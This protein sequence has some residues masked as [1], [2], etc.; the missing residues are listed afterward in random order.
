LK[1]RFWLILGGLA[2]LAIIVV[3]A[4][5]SSGSR[6]NQNPADLITCTVNTDIGIDKVTITNQNTGKSITKTMTDLPYTFNLTEG[7][8]LRLNVTLTEGYVWNA[9]EINQYPWF[10]QDNPFTMKVNEAVILN[11]KCLA[12]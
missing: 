5:A 1:Q 6:R 10:A 11:P 7:D 2:L 12:K 4:S 9:W 3:A 8:T